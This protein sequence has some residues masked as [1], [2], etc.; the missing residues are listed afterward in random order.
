MKGA[1]KIRFEMD[2]LYAGLVGDDPT[3]GKPKS[4]ISAWHDAVYPD[5]A[6][7]NKLDYTVISYVDALQDRLNCCLRLFQNGFMILVATADGE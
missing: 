4:A 1:T 5:L 7:D 6:D 3:G 2:K